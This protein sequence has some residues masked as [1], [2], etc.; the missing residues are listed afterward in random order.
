MGENG[1]DGTKIAKGRLEEAIRALAGRQ[2]GNV[3]RRQRL[4]LG[5][6]S[7][8]INARLRNGS[9]V[10]RCPG[11]YALAPARIDPHAR[12][13]AAVLAGGPYALA[14][15]TSAAFLWG[16]ITH[17][18]PPPHIPAGIAVPATSSSTTSATTTSSPSTRSTT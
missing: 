18:E 11:V 8:A 7:E 9:Y 6:S 16:F 15:H 4:S 13:A 17:F 2:W 14:S 10:S 3:S 12:I 1:S 5:L